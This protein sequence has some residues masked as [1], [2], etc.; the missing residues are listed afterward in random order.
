MRTRLRSMKSRLGAGKVSMCIM[1]LAWTFPEAAFAQDA[2]DAIGT[3]CQPGNPDLC[4]DEPSEAEFCCASGECD[5]ASLTCC[6]C[7]GPT[8]FPHNIDAFHPLTD[9]G[10]PSYQGTHPLGLYVYR[11]TQNGPLVYSN[12]IP[13]LHKGFGLREGDEIYPRNDDGA[14]DLVNGYIGVVSIGFSNVNQEFGDMLSD[15][16]EGLTGTLD[17]LNDRLV[18]VNGAAPNHVMCEWSTAYDPGDEDD[19]WTQLIGG[20]DVPDPKLK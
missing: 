19:I 15:K 14:K 4:T 16:I 6:P 5:P 3:A 9:V 11:E 20:E 1:A 18:F 17:G 10:A 7:A 8:A 13:A 2:C 12:T